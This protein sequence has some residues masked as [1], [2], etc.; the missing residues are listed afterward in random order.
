[1]REV[2]L[3]FTLRHT[4]QRMQELIFTSDTHL[5]TLGNKFITNISSCTVCGHFIACSIVALIEQKCNQTGHYIRDM[6]YYEF[7]LQIQ[8]LVFSYLNW[9]DRHEMLVSSGHFTSYV[10]FLVLRKEI[11]GVLVKTLQANRYVQCVPVIY[12][13]IY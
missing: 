4:I 7:Y 13:F 1:M 5:P 8:E 2:T 12:L 3:V 10:H 11:D 6:Q 9:N